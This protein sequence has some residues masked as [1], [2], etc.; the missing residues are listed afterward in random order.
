MADAALAPY[1]APLPL[2][3][4]SRGS[5]RFAGP[6]GGPHGAKMGTLVGN[7]RGCGPI[8]TTRGT[9]GD[10]GCETRIWKWESAAGT[11]TNGSECEMRVIDAT[12]R[13]RWC[14]NRAA[15]AGRSRLLHKQLLSF[16][17]PSLAAVVAVRSGRRRES[18]PAVNDA[19]FTAEI[20]CSICVSSRLVPSFIQRCWSVHAKLRITPAL[21]R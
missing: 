10:G 14:R 15:A 4:R 11:C 9:G 7:P 12:W 16:L 13:R 20:P 3:C 19:L 17:Q 6:F 1:C 21:Q 2:L 8:S 5:H 18:L